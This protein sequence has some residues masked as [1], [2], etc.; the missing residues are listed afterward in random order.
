MILKMGRE[1]TLPC[2]Y[3]ENNFYII[4]IV[5]ICFFSSVSFKANEYVQQ[6]AFKSS[7]PKIL[8]IIHIS[9]LKT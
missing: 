5:C 8:S 7:V 3:R 6:Q 9:I 4:L 1:L 2:L